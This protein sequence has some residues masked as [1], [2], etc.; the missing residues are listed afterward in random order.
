ML[1]TQHNM[2]SV[3][4][5]DRPPSI[6]TVGTFGMFPIINVACRTG[7]CRDDVPKFHARP[8]LTFDNIYQD[9]SQQLLL[10]LYFYNTNLFVMPPESCVPPT[11]G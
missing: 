5:A 6:S 3:V 1:I 9:V 7:C 2:Q 4:D 10:I 11:K 8:L